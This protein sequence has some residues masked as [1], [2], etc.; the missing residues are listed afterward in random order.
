LKQLDLMDYNGGFK[1]PMGIGNHPFYEKQ[2]KAQE[3][4]SKENPYYGFV[5]DSEGKWVDSHFLGVDGPLFHMDID[6]QDVLHYW[7]MSF[8]RHAMV[9]HLTFNLNEK[10]VVE[11]PGL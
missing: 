4:T 1:M 11:D 7:M 5:I 2:D 3:N 9:A 6:N 10:T 8:E